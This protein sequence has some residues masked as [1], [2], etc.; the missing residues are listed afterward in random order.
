[1]IRI[2]CLFSVFV[3][4]SHFQ[5]VKLC[6]AGEVT[7]QL[8]EFLLTSSLGYIINSQMTILSVTVP[9]AALSKL[10]PDTTAE[11]HASPVDGKNC[12]ILCN[13]ILC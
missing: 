7:L 8:L 5:F 2:A 6:E 11:L 13:Q 1:M 10:P 3:G 9:P 12:V 4:I